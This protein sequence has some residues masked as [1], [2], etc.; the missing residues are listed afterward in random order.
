[1]ANSFYGRQFTKKIV[2]GTDKKIRNRNN[3]SMDQFFKKLIGPFFCAPY[4]PTMRQNFENIGTKAENTVQ[5]GINHQWVGSKL[6]DEMNY[7]VIG[8]TVYR[9]LNNSANDTG[10]P[11]GVDILILQKAENIRLESDSNG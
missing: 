7:A 8:Q 4:L 1:M 3:G 10:V 5:V 2:F 6:T 11:N 9:I